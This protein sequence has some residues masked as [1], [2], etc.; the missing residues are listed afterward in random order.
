MTARPTIVFSS[1]FKPFAEANNLYSRVDSKIELFHNQLTKYQGIFSPRVHYNTFGLHAIANNIET[2]SVVLDYPTLGRFIAE[3]KK[4]YD[5]VGIGSIAPNFQ[6]VKRMVEEVRKHSPKSKIILGGFCA[7]IPN[8]DQLLEADHICRG[9]GISFMRELLGQKPEFEF[10]QPDVFS[11]TREVLGVPFFWRD[12]HPYIIVGL[13]CSY[14]CDFCS[15]SHF[16][17]RKHIKLLKTGEAIFKEIERLGK[18]FRSHTFGLIGDDNFLI[19]KKR[20]RELH[21][22]VVRSGRQFDIFIF[23]GADL[24]CEWA[25]E[26]LAE[27]GVCNIWIGRESK[28]AAYGKNQR[29]D[30]KS[31]VEELRGVGIKVILSSILLMDFH[32]RDNIREDIEDHLSSKPAFSQFSFYAPAPGTPLY[33]RLREEGRLL[34]SIPLEE[35]HAFKQPWFVHPEFS[36]VEAEQIQEQAYLD[37]FY[38][39]GPSLV[40]NIRDD[41]E[42]YLRMKD[43]L[44]PRLRERAEFIA[45]KFPRYRPILKACEHLVPR[46]EMR[47]QVRELRLRLEQASRKMGL[48]ENVEALGLWGFGAAGGLRLRFWGDG[49]QPR[50]RVYH[51]VG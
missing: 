27:M 10:R 33:E 12:Y 46:P 13:G 31:L 50:T 45:A 15:P 34:D 11:E 28:F 49:L 32:T 44:N 26:E 3:V 17:G 25:P 19:D 36:L 41:L 43:S 37:D 8:L 51:Y 24:V 23:A 9:E 6:K 42:G 14:G 39:L 40:R 29:L 18:K 7:G 35:W 2:D 16:F 48:V 22:L 5:Y 38:R 20:A 4:G 47:E 21:D 30:M 1:V